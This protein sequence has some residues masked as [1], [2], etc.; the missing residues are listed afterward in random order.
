[1]IW[2]NGKVQELPTLAGDSE[3]VAAAINDNGQAVG[4]SGTCAAFDPNSGLYLTENHAVLWQN[5][6]VTDLGNLGGTGANG[7]NHACAINNQGQVVGHSE[8]PDDTTFHGFLWTAATGMQDLGTL[9][10]DFASNGNS[11]NDR[12]EVVGLSLDEN[13]NPRAFLWENGVMTDLNTLIPGNSD[14]Y[15][16]LAYSINSSGEIVGLAATSTGDLHGFR[17]TP[18]SGVD[19]R[20]SAAPVAP[21]MT[22]R[23]VLSEDA[24][25]QRS[26]YRKGR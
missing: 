10:G 6:T 12:G 22:H 14:L 21:G 9:P 13:F 24:R 1:M 18:S 8:L 15:L 25:K 26:W 19:A 16:L 20:D 2:A 4:S 23:M 5:G 7:G 11:I 3:G 17:A